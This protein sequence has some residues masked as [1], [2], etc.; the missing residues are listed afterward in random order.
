VIG[1]KHTATVLSARSEFDAFLFA[2]IGEE[3]NGTPLSVLS[4]LAR[5]EALEPF[6]E[7]SFDVGD[8]GAIDW[9]KDR[10]MPK[11]KFERTGRTGQFAPAST[12]ECRAGSSA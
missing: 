2:S 8:G 10:A 6:V 9:F 11:V 5:L 1:V 7:V 12:V 4:A 3:K